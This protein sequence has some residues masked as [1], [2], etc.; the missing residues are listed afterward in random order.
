MHGTDLS[1]VNMMFAALPAQLYGQYTA[2]VYPQQATYSD[3]S[4][5]PN[6]AS[7]NE[8]ANRVTC[9][10]VFEHTKKHFPEVKNIKK[11]LSEV[12]LQLVPEEFTHKFK[13]ASF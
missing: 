13:E 1:P 2:A 5:V 3:P 6:Y 8:A 10:A 4:I 11:A 12:F 9:K 7:V